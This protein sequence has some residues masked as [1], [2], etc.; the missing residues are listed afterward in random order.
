MSASPRTSTS[1]P[2]PHAAS[3]DKACT[4]LQSAAVTQGH[5]EGQQVGRAMK[6]SAKHPASDAPGMIGAAWGALDI[7]W[8]HPARSALPQDDGRASRCARRQQVA[9]LV[10]VDLDVAHLRAW[11][12]ALTQ[13]TGAHA[14]SR[15]L[16]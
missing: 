7:L 15:V 8:G 6:P 12:T 10:L 2:Q 13:H 1:L 9:D 5:V 3:A 14:A 16:S 11:H 4:A